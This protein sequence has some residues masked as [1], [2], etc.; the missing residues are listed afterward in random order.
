MDSK[1]SIL[2]EDAGTTSSLSREE[3]ETIERSAARARNMVAG[4]PVPGEWPGDPVPGQRPGDPV[5]AERP[6]DPVPAERPGDPVPGREPQ[7]PGD[8]VACGQRQR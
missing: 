5:P 6:G 2:R 7:E 1:Q 3:V 4:D 8:P